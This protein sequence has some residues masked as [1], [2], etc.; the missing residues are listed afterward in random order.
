LEVNKGDPGLQV[1]ILAAA[2][3]MH[4][5]SELQDELDHYTQLNALQ[6]EAVPV[7]LQGAADKKLEL[8]E[9]RGED[10]KI[11]TM[12]QSINHLLPTE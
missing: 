2:G 3:H 5:G 10:L 4:V 12:G 1:P 7:T 8:N 6:D 9:I 11:D